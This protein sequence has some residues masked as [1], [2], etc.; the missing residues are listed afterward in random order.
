MKGAKELNEI[1]V[2]CKECET[3]FSTTNG[4]KRLCPFCREE[5]QKEQKRKHAESQ[6]VARLKKKFGGNAKI[7]ND[8]N[9]AFELGVSYGVYMAMPEK[10]KLSKKMGRI[11]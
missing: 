9:N 1:I 11:G 7:I 5:R 3:E 10:V 8:A 6:R 4:K 2:K